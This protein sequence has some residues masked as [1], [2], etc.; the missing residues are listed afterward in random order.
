MFVPLIFAM[1]KLPSRNVT[2]DQK[3]FQ[4]CHSARKTDFYQGREWLANIIFVYPQGLQKS[5]LVG[6]GY[7]VS[8]NMYDDIDLC[9]FIVKGFVWYGQ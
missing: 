5:Y 2:E 9:S 7:V 8:Y 6:K 4:A 1:L 3:L